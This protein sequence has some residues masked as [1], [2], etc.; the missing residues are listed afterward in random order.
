M[1]LCDQI[2]KSYNQYLE[3]EE[4]NKENPNWRYI[5]MTQLFGL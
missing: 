1:T 2:T 3:A 5:M 4:D